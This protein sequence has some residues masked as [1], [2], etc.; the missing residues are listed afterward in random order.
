ML[1]SPLVGSLMCVLAMSQS[2]YTQIIQAFLMHIYIWALWEESFKA[3]ILV[4]KEVYVLHGSRGR[5]I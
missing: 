2:V 3:H 4:N 5:V 1:H